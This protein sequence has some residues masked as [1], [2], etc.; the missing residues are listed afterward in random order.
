M[1]THMF[2]LDQHPET[3]HL[4]PGQKAYK[5]IDISETE[6]EVKGCCSF[7][8]GSS[9]VNVQIYGQTQVKTN[10]MLHGT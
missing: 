7:N 1:Q 5:Q 6:L 4:E 8:G 10:H 9:R 3:E 2:L